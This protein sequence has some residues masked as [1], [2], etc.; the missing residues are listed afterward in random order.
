MSAAETE[1]IIRLLK[2]FGQRIAF[3]G[4][5][6]YRARAYHTAAES[7]SAISDPIHAIIDADELT[8]L[9]GIGDALADII[10][11][12]HTTGSHPKLEELRKKIPQGVLEIAE[13]PGLR[14]EQ[15][16]KIYQ[17][18]KIS[19]IET[20][21][22]SITA[23]KLDHVKGFT[24]AFKNKI[25]QGIDIR[26]QSKGK[27]HIHRAAEI[28]A[29]T[30]K[31][32][33]ATYP[34]L[35]KIASAGEFRRKCPLIGD[36]VFVAASEKAKA[37]KSIKL[38]SE[39]ELQICAPEIYGSRLLFATGSETHLS[40]LVKLAEEKNMSLSAQG[41][42]SGRKVI[43]SESEKDIYKALGL[44]YIEPEM[45]EGRGEIELARKKRLPKL[46]EEKDLKGVLH[47]HTTESDGSNT[48]E[49]M[50]A[51]VRQR[52]FQYFGLSDH[53]QSAH[54]AG[55]LKPEEILPQQKEVD[56]LNKR[57]GKEFH[58]FKGIESDIRSDGSLDYPEDI[59]KTFDFIVASVH[60]Q[61]KMSEEEQTARIVKA[62]ENPYTTILGHMTGRQLLRRPGYE[63]DIETVLKACA[64]NGV[65]VEINANPWRLDVDW[66]WHRTA[67]KFGC[68]LSVNPDAHATGEIDLMKWGIA[69]AR[70]GGISKDRIL[71]C[72]D[73]AEITAFLKK[74]KFLR[75]KRAK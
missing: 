8:A 29:A 61:F 12:I 62:V 45:R 46:V 33:S 26:R 13:I 40:E 57:Y 75:K 21:E 48:L 58:I 51:A 19:D 43:A 15:V 41:L 65:V 28:V 23:G 34:E 70:K 52:G 7:L 24:P 1:D 73:L 59:L 63:L 50:V 39:A 47:A 17:D 18:A 71:N 5:N 42:K 25:L 60:S 37:A 27:R 6:P 14:S 20:L 72:M 69:M 30:L 11:K 35:K 4:G 36:F 16:V 64:D 22:K 56:R 44:A 9:P 66:H 68:M 32:I 31:N 74:R 3:E 53:S 67:L 54:Y 49:E 55:G 10:K 2:E 38:G